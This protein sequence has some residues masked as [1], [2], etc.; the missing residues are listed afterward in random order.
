MKGAMYTERCVKN[1]IVKH[2]IAVFCTAILNL[3]SFY[4]LFYLQNI[5]TKTTEVKNIT[6]IIT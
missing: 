5:L 3:P 2:V 4:F 6:S 1:I